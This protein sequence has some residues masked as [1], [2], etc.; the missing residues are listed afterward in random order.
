[1]NKNNKNYKVF[2]ETLKSRILSNPLWNIRPED[3]RFYPDGY[4]GGNDP[5]EQEFVLQTNMKYHG[6]VSDVL[7][8]D[9]ISIDLRM[10]G[11]TICMCRFC[12][13]YLFAEYQEEGWEKVEFILQENIELAQSSN[14]DF[15]FEHLS[16][17]EFMKKRLMMRCVN[18]DDHKLELQQYVHKVYGDIAVVLYA[19]LYDDYRGLGAMKIPQ[20]LLSDWNV[21]EDVLLEEALINTYIYAQPRLYTNLWDT[22]KT[23][24]SKGAFMSVASDIESI[25]K[26]QVPLV[27][28]TKKMNG[29]IAMFYP[30]VKEKIAK[31]FGG[32]YYIAF[33]SIH[34][35]RIHHCDSVSPNLVAKS[36]QDVNDNSEKEE[37]LSRQVFC[38]DA[39]KKIFEP[40]VLE[41]I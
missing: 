27:T 3:Y 2:C 30:G 10:E 9:F 25:E 28:T 8:G 12:M 23:P 40:C 7:K 5:K 41:N 38:Y 33:T 19:K 37:I 17:Y 24:V 18:Y 14:L 32:S 20:E 16:D 11:E 31:L 35:A 34:E 29:A 21:A 26:F 4:C 1:M 6:M 13:E 15:I 22:L 36:L 39:E